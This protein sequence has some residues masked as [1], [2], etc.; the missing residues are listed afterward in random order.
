MLRITGRGATALLT[1]DTEANAEK[2]LLRDQADK[3]ANDILALL[4][5]SPPT[6]SGAGF[7]SAVNPEFA[8]VPTGYATRYGF[9][10]SEVIVRYRAKLFQRRLL[11]LKARRPLMCTPTAALRYGQ[12][13]VKRIG[14]TGPRALKR[15]A[16]FSRVQPCA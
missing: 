5:M 1:R 13:I 11:E 3:L 2:R 4:F 9:P 10:K 16:S 6:S 8:L 12:A 14:L 7:I 15:R